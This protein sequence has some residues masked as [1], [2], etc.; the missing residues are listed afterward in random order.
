[1]SICIIDYNVGNIGSVSNAFQAIGIRA[2]V[3][4]DSV[5]IAKA[6]GIILPGV[7][8]FEAGMTNLHKLG[9]LEILYEKVVI[10][11]TPILGIC[12]GMQLFAQQG[13][14]NG[15]H[16]GLGFIPGVVK[17]IPTEAQV[18]I[19]HIG[20]NEIKF[21][22]KE[23]VLLKNLELRSCFY[24]VHS[25]Y[26]DTDSLLISSYTDYGIPLTASVERNNI[27]G[28]QFHPEKSQQ[29][30]LL[31]LKNF[32]NYVYEYS[33]AQTHSMSVMG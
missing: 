30:G 28:V 7:G 13:E 8:A 24:F 22:S 4:N 11:K 9:L 12:L 15:L 21:A 2:D 10:K 6:N 20:W 17:K 27:F 31:L 29:A 14:E 3:T 18:K 1:M 19:P 33:E 26:L 16:N 25:F 23:S 5:F 32:V